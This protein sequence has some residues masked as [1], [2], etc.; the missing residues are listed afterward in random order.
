[1]L[2]FSEIFEFSSENSYFERIRTVR[3][4][5]MVRSI[6]DR[7]F[8]LR[9]G[10]PPFLQGPTSRRASRSR[11]PWHAPLSP[12]P[13]SGLKYGFPSFPPWSPTQWS[14]FLFLLE[15]EQVTNFFIRR[16]LFPAL[17]FRMCVYKNSP[18]RAEANS[19]SG[20]NDRM[21]DHE[22]SS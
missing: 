9:P 21:K 12:L 11:P 5:R 1:M 16:P 2:K 19:P 20:F 6:A 4:V 3:M 7:T 8:Q 18:C 14:Y 10:P 15:N 22:R 13:I 17:N